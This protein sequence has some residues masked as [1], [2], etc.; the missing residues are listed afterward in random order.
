MLLLALYDADGRLISTTV[1]DYLDES[2]WRF[3]SEL[4][5]TCSSMKVIALDGE[6]RPLMTAMLYQD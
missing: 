5:A 1:G 3:N 6:S 4:A 2:A